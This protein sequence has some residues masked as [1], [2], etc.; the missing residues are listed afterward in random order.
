MKNGSLGFINNEKHD[1]GVFCR[2]MKAAL[3]IYNMPNECLVVIPFKGG[4][5]PFAKT[6]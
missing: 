2:S 5:D 4:L 3:L 6:E 1:E